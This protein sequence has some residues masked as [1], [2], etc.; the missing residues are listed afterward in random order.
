MS[1]GSVSCSSGGQ[2]VAI[3]VLSNSYLY[4]SSNYGSTF[5][6]Y[7]LPY[8]GCGYVAVSATGQYMVTAQTS[9]NPQYIMYSTTGGTTWQTYYLSNTY[10]NFNRASISG[11][12]QYMAMSSSNGTYY[13]NNYGSSWSTLLV[14]GMSSVYCVVF[15]YSGVYQTAQSSSTTYM[16]SNSGTS[17]SSTLSNG[18]SYS[19][20]VMSYSGAN[21]LFNSYCYPGNG[22]YGSF[23]QFNAAYNIAGGVAS[24]STTTGQLTI[25]G[26]L[27][28]SGAI[29]YSGGSVG[30]DYRI[31]QNIT[32]LDSTFT[33]DNLN[34]VKYYNTNLNKDDFGLIAHELQEQYPILVSGEKD[35][36][37]L[38]S[39]NYY[40]VIPLLINELQH[41]KRGKLFHSVLDPTL[42][43]FIFD[44]NNK[45][46]FY[47][48]SVPAENFTAY[49]I[50]VPTSDNQLYTLSIILN[51]ST[52]KNFIHAVNVN[53]NECTLL[54]DGGVSN[55]NISSSSIVIQ[56]FTFVNNGSGNPVLVLSEINPYN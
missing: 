9:N 30:S 48:D 7:S 56:K 40:G 32:S 54:I 38:Q 10:L 28:V 29:Y 14:T 3:G 16:S 27:G 33:V 2:I 46:T 42:N 47:V 4:I 49:F 36:H 12:G 1:A 25:T 11:N 51:T 5:T 15:S 50:H 44:Y 22:S 43:Q 37:Y 17:W 55:V 18:N 19:Q 45:S 41:V 26:G 20:I 24:N 13:S 8:G 52:N 34:P 21:Q 31:K 53:G 35:G 23:Y 6:S 39:V